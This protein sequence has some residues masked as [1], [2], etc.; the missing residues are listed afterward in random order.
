MPPVIAAVAAF[1]TTFTAGAIAG[2]AATLIATV[3][4]DVVVATILTVAS[5]ALAPKPKSGKSA[6]LLQNYA[7]TEASMVWVYG[8]I[9][10]GGM[11]TIPAITSNV[12]GKTNGAFLN[13]VLT[14]A[15]R[16]VNDITNVYLNSTLVLDAEIAAV[17]GVTGDGSV[18]TPAFGNGSGSHLWIR[19]Y[20]G[21]QTT[22]DWKLSN[23]VSTTAFTNFVGAGMAYAAMTMWWDPDIWASGVPT[24]TFDVLGHSIYDPRLD[25][26]NGG[27]GSQ[28]FAN[29]ASWAPSNNPAL[30]TADYLTQA[31]SY[32]FTE[33]DWA[34]VIAAANICD[35]I[36]AEY[37]LFGSWTQHLTHV[38]HTTNADGTD[39]FTSS[40]GVA[41]DYSE[42]Y[43]STLPVS[44]GSI[45]FKVTAGTNVAVAF[46]KSS[47]FTNAKT[48]AQVCG[49]E[50]DSLGTI[51]VNA[52]GTLGVFG[53]GV[54][55]TGTTSLVDI[56][57]LEY[58]GTCI[59]CYAHYI[60]SGNKQTTMRQLLFVV[61]L[62]AADV[63]RV[64]YCTVGIASATGSCTLNV[65]RR[66]TMNGQMAL[67]DSFTSNLT[68]LVDAMLGRLIYTNGVW[69]MFA[70][71][72][73]AA[74][75]AINENDWVSNLQFT[76]DGGRDQRFNRVRSWYIDPLQN[77]QRVECFPRADPTYQTADGG[78]WIDYETDQP[79]C[80]SD[81]ECQRKAEM[82]LH[83]SRNQVTVS[84]KLPP[85]FQYLMMW[86]TVTVNH[87]L[88]GWF[89]KNFIVTSCAINTDGSVDVALK[90]GQSTDW[91]DM[92][93]SDYN[94]YSKAKLPAMNPTQ[95]SEPTS[96]TITTNIDGTLLFTIGD[97]IT[98]TIDTSYRIIMS[99]NS[100]DATAGVELWRGQA[101]AVALLCPSIINWY[102]AQSVTNSYQSPYFPNT[103]GIAAEPDPTAQHPQGQ[104]ATSD[105]DFSYSQRIGRFWNVDSPGV[106]AIVSQP[107]SLSATGGLSGGSC[108]ITWPSSLAA[109]DHSYLYSVPT[110]PF[111]KW[112]QGQNYTGFMRMRQVAPSSFRSDPGGGQFDIALMAWNGVGLPNSSNL[113]PLGSVAGAIQT[114]S[115]AA[116]SS[117]SWIDSFYTSTISTGV[118]PNSYPYVAMQFRTPANV[119][120]GTYRID[121]LDVYIR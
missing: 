16:A 95:P 47:S 119:I 99:P 42:G 86:D 102:Y 21:V 116:V 8:Q 23:E 98:K 74:S 26:T 101:N 63:G 113:V 91:T 3:A 48:S 39:K 4:V 94:T 50:V 100:H 69:R 96:L 17:T 72:W 61:K 84:G 30:V 79:F 10:V 87:N 7:S 88:L 51:N 25:T 34:A 66:Y 52:F 67:N 37:D 41:A 108:I 68:S 121:Y 12:G 71:A 77:W 115:L 45:K 27:S 58:D 29:Q 19:R 43:I 40:A 18:S 83:Q 6:G 33:I 55:T 111:P 104:E 14:I 28:T 24:Y 38:T 49:F 118:V 73:S 90:E 13:R 57:E 85:R 36:V 110:T 78:E 31:G 76:F 117:G 60:Y 64:M 35:Q 92:V 114:N 56:L 81:P 5:K 15:G 112:V 65:C 9:R 54:L 120:N 46:S 62:A 70:G 93:A 105:P 32:Q 75:S 53:A 2:T 106:G 107:F 103:F 59:Y 11:D 109:G 89:S 22:P 44:R 82:T 20:L 80:L 1:I 97:A